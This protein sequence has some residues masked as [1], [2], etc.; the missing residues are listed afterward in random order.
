MEPLLPFLRLTLLKLVC[1]RDVQRCR[2]N[3]LWPVE[4]LSLQELSR[5]EVH[6]YAGARDALLGRVEKCAY[7]APAS[8]FKA[9]R[10]S[11]LM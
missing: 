6:L 8:R 9:S 10:K 4:R 2:Q 11:N 1:H 3:R 5:N 7:R